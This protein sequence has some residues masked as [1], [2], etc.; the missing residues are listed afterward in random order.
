MNELELL[1]DFRAGVPAPTAEATSAARAAV[2]RRLAQPRAPWWRRRLV[3]AIAFALLVLGGAGT[4]LG[5]GD[6]LVDL[7]RG[8][9]APSTFEKLMEITFGDRL[10]TW[11]RG[12]ELAGDWR[13]VT[14]SQT[15]IGPAAIYAA[16]TR[17]G[18]VC[19]QGVVVNDDVTVLQQLLTGACGPTTW[20]PTASMPRV[21][22]ALERRQD[23]GPF[24]GG[25]KGTGQELTI[26]L[27]RAA[28][29]VETI[30]VRMRG[31]SV[32]IRVHET[33]FIQYISPAVSSAQLIGLDA[34]GGRVD[35]R[36]YTVANSFD[37]M[38]GEQ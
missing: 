6:A 36:P 26:L 11:M 4:A 7:I 27:G 9:P 18:G 29:P 8:K 19:W 10:P 31:R 16:P 14:A 28:P 30:L 21:Y 17:N 22:A 23:C 34:E 12:Y 13:G 20:T 32:R 24:L 25:S 38:C 2:A 3:V 15:P 35:A 33:F 5:L 1:Q 37:S